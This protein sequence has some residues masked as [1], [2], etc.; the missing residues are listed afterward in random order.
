M[1]NEI[2]RHGYLPIVGFCFLLNF[3]PSIAATEFDVEFDCYRDTSSCQQTASFTNRFRSAHLS[4][5]RWG[6]SWSPGQPHGAAI[7]NTSGGV[8]MAVRVKALNGDT[9]KRNLNAGGHLFGNVWRK[10]DGTEMI[11]NDAFGGT[12]IPIN[13][14]VWNRVSPRTPTN[15]YENLRGQI[16]TANFEV[17]QDGA[18]EP[19]TLGPIAPAAKQ[20]EAWTG[21]LRSLPA[22]YQDIVVY[23]ESNDGK[24]ILFVS[25][26]SLLIYEDATKQL[27]H[28][29]PDVDVPTGL[30]R[31]TSENNTFSL[32]RNGVKA[33]DID[34]SKAEKQKVTDANKMQHNP[35]HSH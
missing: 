15:P 10:S 4:E 14:V 26:E 9:F 25:Q 20:T 32:W 11:F 21:L 18:W 17:P 6:S 24:S 33:L 8:V 13:K 31:I 27:S 30:N 23:G 34:A 5:V 7:T 12:G 19:M 1:R 22:R 35:D 28:V 3:N 16:S 2:R 29:F